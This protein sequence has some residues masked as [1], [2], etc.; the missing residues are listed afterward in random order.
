MNFEGYLYRRIK[1]YYFVS[2]NPKSDL[3]LLFSLSVGVM[4]FERSLSC[5]ALVQKFK[6]SSQAGRRFNADLISLRRGESSGLSP[7]ESPNGGGDVS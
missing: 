3:E 6:T 7:N 4:E 1:A 5:S 2:F